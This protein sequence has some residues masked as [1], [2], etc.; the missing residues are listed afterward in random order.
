MVIIHTL[1]EKG[2]PD[3]PWTVIVETETNIVLHDLKEH[4]ELREWNKLKQKP[5]KYE[6]EVEL[7]EGFLARVVAHFP[8]EWYPNI[9]KCRRKY[10]ILLRVYGAPEDQLVTAK[11]QVSWP[12]YLAVE[13]HFVVLEADVRGSGYQSLEMSS[14]IWRQLGILE[15][16]D[17]LKIVKYFMDNVKCLSKEGAGVFG[18]GYGGYTALNVMAT[19]TQNLI[20]CCA[21]ISPITTWEHYSYTFGTQIFGSPTLDEEH[22]L[23]Y[24]RSNLLLLIKCI[25]FCTDLRE[26]D[27]RRG[28]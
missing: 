4:N 23:L 10:R 13:K 14:K 6:F 21:A 25:N 8:P 27:F 7:Y 17:Q 20:Q 24:E 19:D 15:V 12:W 5:R 26:P 2:G 16:E 18:E 1:R 3:V 9:K 28:T 11:Y 22:K